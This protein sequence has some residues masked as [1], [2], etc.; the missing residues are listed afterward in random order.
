M[1]IVNCCDDVWIEIFS[2]LEPLDII[3]S[4]S[5]TCKRLN[6]LSEMCFFLLD[7][8]QD[9]KQDYSNFEDYVK[10]KLLNDQIQIRYEENEYYIPI[11]RNSKY[12]IRHY[13]LKLSV[14]LSESIGPPWRYDR[15]R[16]LSSAISED[17]ELFQFYLSRFGFDNSNTLLQMKDIDIDTTNMY[18]I[19]TVLVGDHGVGK[20]T[21]FTSLTREQFSSARRRMGEEISGKHVEFLNHKFIVQL[22]DS[23]CESFFYIPKIVVRY[24][25]FAVYCFSVSNRKSLL[26]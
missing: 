7:S 19:K 24:C 2:F 23:V 18:T 6:E 9:F 25:N 10:L 16:A 1:S 15:N 13:L 11:M 22:W 26:R 21:L 14:K 3:A 5:G 8:S 20:S 4:V 12:F 17:I